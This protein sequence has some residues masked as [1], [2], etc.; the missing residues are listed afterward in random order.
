MQAIS[1]SPTSGAVSDPDPARG[2]RRVQRGISPT[3][4][5]IR[6]VAS[7]FDTH[8]RV[9]ETRRVHQCRRTGN[10]RARTATPRIRVRRT[11]SDL[12]TI[13]GFAAGARKDPPSP[14]SS[15]FFVTKSAPHYSE[16]D[17]RVLRPSGWARVRR[18][19]V[20]SA[21]S[22]PARFPAWGRA[23]HDRGRP[24][25]RESGANAGGRGRPAAKRGAAPGMTGSGEDSG[26]QVEEP[27][28]LLASGVS[29]GAIPA[30]DCTGE[31]GEPLPRGGN[32]RGPRG[33][34]GPISRG[35]GIGPGESPGGTG[36]NISRG[37][38]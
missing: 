17:V 38:R 24:P 4:A 7:I 15:A 5:A 29:G 13:L 12:L 36:G 35:S 31:R 9:G 18:W 2:S 22:N 6:A 8:P 3:P 19:P 37:E 32:G 33:A 10:P 11:G 28:G 14:S 30:P 20:A 27:G 23:S 1:S 16:M 25:H 34:A 21:Q 26:R